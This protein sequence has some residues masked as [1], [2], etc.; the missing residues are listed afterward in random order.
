MESSLWLREAARIQERSPHRLGACARVG[1]GLGLVTGSRQRPRA[2]V[3]DDILDITQST[4]VLGKT[5]GKDLLS[6]KAT[7]PSL[8]GL[9]RSRQARPA[10]RARGAAA[11]AHRPR[12]RRRGAVARETKPE[13]PPPAPLT[14]ACVQRHGAVRRL[15]PDSPLS[16]ACLRPPSWLPFDASSGPWHA[17]R[18][19]AALGRWPAS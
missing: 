1:V 15:A 9:E 8:L 17:T 5:A 16:S 7:Y 18:D 3:V 6:D 12:P 2:Q 13:P 14:A 4:E 19:A 10:R 11:R